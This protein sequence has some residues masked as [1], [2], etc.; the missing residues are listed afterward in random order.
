[1]FYFSMTSIVLLNIYNVNKEKNWNSLHS[2]TYF[3][4]INIVLNIITVE[5]YYTKFYK[6]NN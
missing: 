4:F 6:E 3:N 2:L 5:I 1:M